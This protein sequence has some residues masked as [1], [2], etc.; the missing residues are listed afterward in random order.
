[1]RLLV[2]L[3]SSTPGAPEALVVYDAASG[4]VDPV[5][6]LDSGAG[7]FGLC[8]AEDTI[9]CLIDHGRP[10]PEEPERSELCAL[11]SS[12]LEVRWRYSFRLGRDVHSV[13]AGAVRIFVTSAGTDE[14]LELPL[15]D[16]GHVRDERVV[17][18][19]DPSGE[20]A[21]HHHLNDV[22][23]DGDRVLVSGFGPRPTPEWRWKDAT[24]GF[25]R[26]LPSG[27]LVMGPVY[28]PHSICRLSADE[29]ALCESPRRQVVTSGGRRSAPLPGYARGLCLAGGSLWVGTSRQR[30]PSEEASILDY[31]PDHGSDEPGICAI[32]RLDTPTLQIQEVIPLDPHGREVY[33]I[34]RLHS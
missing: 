28:Q 11:D 10:D 13:A 31:A 23:I 18:R 22:V 17:W 25:V 33:D 15:D 7:A 1:M 3:C 5:P 29:L 12:T 6:L 24:A 26:A 19:P 8:V 16:R 9:Y 27:E 30:R 2:S 14:V 34:V 32:S 20:R 4:R 21:D